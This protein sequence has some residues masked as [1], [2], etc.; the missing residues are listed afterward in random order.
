MKKILVTT[1]KQTFGTVEVEVSE[2][3]PIF[4]ENLSK[5]TRMHYAAALAKKNAEQNPNSVTW[6]N[7]DHVTYLNGFWE[8]E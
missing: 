6:D 3:S 2:D 8:V 7:E 1:M 5:R 4:N